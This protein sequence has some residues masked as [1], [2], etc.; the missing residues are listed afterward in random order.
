MKCS[1]CDREIP[2]EQ[3]GWSFGNNAMPVNDG[4][5]CDDCNWMVVIPMRRSRLA[6]D[7]NKEK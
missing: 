1:I 5:C 7:D 4:R 3:S 2:V 6:S